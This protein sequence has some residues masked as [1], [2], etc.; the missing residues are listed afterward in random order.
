[1]E[2]FARQRPLHGTTVNTITIAKP[3]TSSISVTTPNGG[4]KWKTGKSYTLKWT[5]KTAGDNVKIQLLKSG[6]Q[7]KWISKSTKNDGE[8]SWKIPAT[9]ATGSAYTIKITSTSKKTVTDTSN[10][11]FTITKSGGD[12]DDDEDGRT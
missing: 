10:K 12:D 11:N 9:V 4:Q 1:M 2:I 6:K 7:Y 5:H 3:D 8:H